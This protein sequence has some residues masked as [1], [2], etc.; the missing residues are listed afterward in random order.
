MIFEFEK[1]TIK[2]KSLSS[3]YLDDTKLSKFI[4]LKNAGF[5]TR[6][7]SHFPAFTP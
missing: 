6:K 7:V 4:E 3:A 5:P 2:Y 1:E